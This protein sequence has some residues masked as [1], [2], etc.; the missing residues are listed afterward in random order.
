[1]IRS[2]GEHDPCVGTAHTSRALDGRDLTVRRGLRVTTPTRTIFDLAGCQHPARTR[3]DL[4]DLWSRGLVSLE[5]LDDA[6]A[7]LSC[8]GRP[9][10][11][12]MRRLVEELRELGVPAGSNL[13]LSVEGLFPLAGLR[14]MRRQVE[15]GGGS[16]VIARVDFA[17]LELSIVVEVDSDR[18]HHGLVDRQL[19]A[20]KT[21]RLQALGLTVV[22]ITE[23][24]V[25]HDRSTLVAR[26]RRTAW[27]CRSRGTA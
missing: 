19:D 9:G 4:N 5:L 1:M 25:W 21:A 11:T 15:I 16:G 18:F 12:T 2:R 14:G 3:R 13:E 26:L 10:I 24:E 20:T 27:E 6:M 17:D 23:Q 22:R 8:K 7:R